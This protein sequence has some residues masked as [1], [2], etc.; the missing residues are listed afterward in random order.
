MPCSPKKGPGGI[1]CEAGGISAGLSEKT[2]R[3][4]LEAMEI[5]A[6]GIGIF[7]PDDRLI[8]SNSANAALFGLTPQQAQG[9]TFEELV[10]HCYREHVGINIE[11]DDIEQWLAMAH[12]K[13]RRHRYRS[14]QTDMLDGR[15][16]QLTEQLTEGGEMFTFFTDI[17]EQKRIERKLERL[18]AKLS[19]QANTDD[20]TG[21][22]NRRN[23]LRLAQQE[24][25]RCR[26]AGR[27]CALLVIDVDF[28]KLVNDEYGHQVGDCVLCNI[29]AALS[30]EL[31]EYDVLG[32]LGGEEFAALIPENGTV[33][34]LEVAERLR[35]AVVSIDHG[36]VC[37]GLRPTIS[38]GLAVSEGAGIALDW[39]I[40]RADQAL[41]RA[42]NAGRNCCVLWSDA[43]N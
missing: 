23:F 4:L 5:T 37:D 20:L 24:V 17:T 39:L 14:F 11:T 25:S 9:K 10:R 27:D 22:N 1:D 2:L 35:K 26:R 34:A 21:I 8:F 42:K 28:F 33:Q 32:R 15:W 40:S 41:Y 18:T 7:D 38:V 19:T 30:K 3:L 31:R 16:V 29:T 36:E 6:D 43:G 12:Q 13:R